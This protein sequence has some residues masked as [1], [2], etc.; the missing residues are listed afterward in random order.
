MINRATIIFVVG[1][2]IAMAAFILVNWPTATDEIDELIKRELPI[3]SSKVEVYNFMES[4]AIISSGYNV[5]PDP[6]DESEDDEKVRYV[7]ASIP[8]RSSLPFQGDSHI[9]IVFYF[10]EESNYIEHKVRRYY[11]VP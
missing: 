9:K 2:L 5:G 6:L 1:V 4:R 8:M 11:E 10:D 3:G 7:I